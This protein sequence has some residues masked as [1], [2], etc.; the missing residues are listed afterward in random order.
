ME[1]PFLIP[2]DKVV[3]FAAGHGDAPQGFPRER[4]PYPINP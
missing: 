1:V 3:T 2:P 4:R